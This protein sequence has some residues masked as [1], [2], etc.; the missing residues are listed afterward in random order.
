MRGSVE[1][2]IGVRWQKESPRGRRLR[3][4]GNQPWEN[5]AMG[6]DTRCTIEGCDKPHRNLGWCNKHYLRVRKYG[7]PLF[8]K[9]PMRVDGTPEERFWGKVDADGD[10]WEWMAH[11]TERG[12]GTFYAP[13]GKMVQAHRYAWEL[14]V[15]PIPE[16][17]E[18]DHLCRNHSCVS[19]PHLEPVP[20]R[21][22]VIRGAASTV[23]KL[24]AQRITHCPYGHEYTPEN[25]MI[26]K[27]TGSRYCRACNR[28][29]CSERYKKM[30]GQ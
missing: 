3:G 4:M 29:R 12:Y 10:C 21:E 26:R 1:P 9:M 2:R 8:T 17:M 19:P 16:G 22:N 30:K 5:A 11:K 20:H 23:Q 18:I 7:D 14:L 13:S 25:T 28:L 24:R 27:G 15:G 6:N